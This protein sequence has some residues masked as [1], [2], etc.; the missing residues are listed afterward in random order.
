MRNLLE[1]PVAKEELV[2]FLADLRETFLQEELCGD[3]RPT[4][5][6][7]LLDLVIGD[8]DETF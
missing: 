8:K 3:L 4:F 2:R 1:Y 5:C 6:N 7:T